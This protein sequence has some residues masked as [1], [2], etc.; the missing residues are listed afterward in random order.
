MRQ[1]EV[2]FPLQWILLGICSLLIRKG[3]DASAGGEGRR[4][5]I[6]FHLHFLITVL[7]VRHPWTAASMLRTTVACATLLLVLPVS[8][9]TSCLTPAP[10]QMKPKYTFSSSP[11]AVVC[12][13]V[14]SLGGKLRQRCQTSPPPP[15]TTTRRLLQ[16]VSPEVEKD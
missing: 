3:H 6:G 2:R 15:N 12:M 14:E 8:F 9:S 4:R 7:F 16:I 5:M 10:H 11:N 13:H 1:K